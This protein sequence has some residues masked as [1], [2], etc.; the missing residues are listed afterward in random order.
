MALFCWPRPSD[1]VTSLRLNEGEVV[2]IA[3]WGGGPSG[4]ELDVFVSGSQVVE[5]DAP[6]SGQKFPDPGLRVFQLKAIMPG[7]GSLVA[8]LPNRVPYVSPVRIIVDWGAALGPNII[9]YYHGD[10]LEEVKKR[11]SEEI[12]PY[13]DGEVGSLGWWDYTDFG[14]GFYTHLE[15]NK[16]MALQWA[17]KRGREKKTD[18]GIL[19]IS[20][21]RSE[22]SAIGGA[23]LVFNTKRVDRPSNAPVLFGGLNANWIEFVE[24]NRHVRVSAQRPGDYDWSSDYSWIRGPFWTKEDSGLQAAPQEETPMVMPDHVH[25]V[26][27]GREGLKAV[28]GDA[29]RRRRFI[30][31]KENKGY[32]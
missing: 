13:T 30:I 32:L 11:F 7:S 17:M 20:L 19:R 9:F 21:L 5:V 2:Q 24:Y 4:E 14:K 16:N 27:W 31:T 29:P 22:F 15:E 3:L 23:S 12:Q 26:N 10:T 6:F 8:L 25:Q 18:W 1:P 28:N